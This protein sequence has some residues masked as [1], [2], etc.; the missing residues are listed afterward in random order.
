MRTTSY[1]ARQSG[2]QSLDVNMA[3]LIDMVFLLLIFFIVTT[4]FVQE[5]GVEIRRPSALTAET[6]ERNAIAIAL[7]AGG[8]IFHDGRR[9]HLNGV[10]GL[11]AQLLRQGPAPVVILADESAR[12][13]LLI[14]LVD[15]CRLG[16]AAQVSVA[17]ARDRA[18]EE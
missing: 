18:G 6:L 3:P 12:S 13:G 14:E 17:A 11:V 10:R 1:A 7:G 9:I 8:E 15:E 2:G 16:G 4:S 5:T